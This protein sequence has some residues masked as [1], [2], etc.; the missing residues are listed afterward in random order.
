MKNKPIAFCTVCKEYSYNASSINEPHRRTKYG[1]TCKGVFSSAIGNDDWIVC[2]NC[3]GTGNDANGKCTQC[4][5][6]G[7]KLN[8]S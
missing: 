7:W 5:G 8:R 6:Y 3:N 1:D 2:S 4:E